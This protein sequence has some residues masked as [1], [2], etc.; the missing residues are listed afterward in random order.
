LSRRG[1]GFSPVSGG[2]KG[3]PDS[4]AKQY[5]KGELTKLLFFGLWVPEL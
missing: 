3:L 1:I 4:T 2:I 5:D